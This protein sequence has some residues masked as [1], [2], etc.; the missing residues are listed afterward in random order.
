MA[1]WTLATLGAEIEKNNLLSREK[2]ITGKGQVFLLWQQ[3]F[4]FSVLD[5]LIGRVDGDCF[6]SQEQKNNFYF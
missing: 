4:S 5:S 3:L 2:K 6:S 1:S